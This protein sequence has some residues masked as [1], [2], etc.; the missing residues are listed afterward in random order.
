MSKP[1]D[2]VRERLLQAGVAPRH[3]R[4]YLGELADHL[5]DLRAEEER[6]GLGRG[7]AE[8]AALLRLGGAEELSRAMIE[9]RQF[10]AWSVRA[11]WAAF[12]V[13]PVC[14][15]A[16]LYFA[17]C[18]VLWSG[19]MIFVPGADTP[20]GGRAHGFPN[21]YFQ[22]GKA[23]YYGA[24]LVV[25]WAVDWMAIRQRAKAAWPIAALVMIAWIGGAA[26]VQAGRT[27]VPGGFGHIRMDFARMAVADGTPD[28]VLHTLLLHTF[29]TLPYLLWRM[30]MAR[31][32]AVSIDRV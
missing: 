19:W 5:S 2:E 13:M 22:A 4:R 16:A 26:Q 10:R 32:P 7:E 17:A 28:I 24:P 6:A 31:S 9:Q 20:F 18:L 27:E 3:V 15:L 11:P 21:I 23:L 1:F 29:T 8:R 14:A 12:G 30:R 25:G